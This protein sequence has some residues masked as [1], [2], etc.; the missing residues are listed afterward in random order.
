MSGARVRSARLA[1]GLSQAAL[2]SRARV[3]RQLVGAIEADRH[4]PRVDAALRIAD[5]L[6]TDVASLFG[7]DPAPLDVQTGAR[8]PDGALLRIGQV[9]DRVVTAP[10]RSGGDGWDVADAA[11]EQGAL[12]V[13]DALA[14]GIVV[15]GCEPGLQVLERILRQQRV[16]A[17]AVA[18]S[19][20]TAVDALAAGRVHAAVVHGPRPEPPPNAAVVRFGLARWAVGLAAPS[21]PPRRWWAAALSGR[22]PVIQREAGAGVQRAF[23]AARRPGAGAPEGPI[24]SSH[25]EAA[26]AAAV[27]GMPAVTIEPAAIAVGAVFHALEVHVAELWVAADLLDGDA[28]GVALD[29]VASRRFQRRLA[30][31]GGYDLTGCGSRVA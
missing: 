4:Q 17:V 23:E 8:P 16:G 20:A 14:P 22:T 27:A 26:R 24:V 31:I 2:A 28:V 30:G 3:S 21:D 13:L 25:V 19:S 6:G 5:A 12:T 10:A 15:A 9:R 18:S 29:A 11:Y 1:L 7:P